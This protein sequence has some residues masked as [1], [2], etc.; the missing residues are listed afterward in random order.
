MDKIKLE[1]SKKKYS[2][3]SV[4]VSVRMPKSML[5]DVDELAANTGR[6]RNELINT[7][8][9]FALKHLLIKEPE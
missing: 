8:I 4:I 2:G 9:E 6:S 1:V 5:S 3:E 7:C